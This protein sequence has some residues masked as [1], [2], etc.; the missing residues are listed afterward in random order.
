MREYSAERLNTVKLLLVDG[1]VSSQLIGSGE[2]LRA[3]GLATDVGTNAG[4][5]SQLT[6]GVSRDIRRKKARTHMLG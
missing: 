1:L 5:C 2:G 6:F 3:S 4:V